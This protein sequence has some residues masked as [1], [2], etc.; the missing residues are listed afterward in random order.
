M[1]LTIDAGKNIC[2]YNSWMQKL[3]HTV[4]RCY[5]ENF[6]DDRGRVWVL[7]SKDKIYDI[8][9]EKILV[10]SN[11]YRITLKDG[12]KSLVVEDTLCNIEGTYA[13]IFK[14]KISQ[15][16]PL[17]HQEKA[18]I[19]VFVAAMMHRTRPQRE[20]MRRMFTELKQTAEK[21]QEEY[22]T[23]SP[24]ERRVLEAVPSSGKGISV[25]ELNQGLENFD[26]KYAADLMSQTMHTAQ[27]IFNMK[28][29]IWKFPPDSSSLVTSDDPMFVERPASIQKYGK[30]TFGSAPGLLYR[31]SEVK[32]PLSRN[33]LFLAGWIIEKDVYLSGTPDMA[34]YFNQRTI[35]NSSEKVIASSQRQLEDIRTKYPPRSPSP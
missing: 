13:E 27:I 3:H 9:P 17:T 5:L 15:Q 16:I 24:E 19:A 11:F 28:W 33:S 31:D 2:R 26:E 4:S 8:R 30:N 32:I 25:G 20:S 6:S 18:N 29:G 12:T 21:W 34:E 22:K 35:L 1:C 10:E 14:N 23:M 7:D